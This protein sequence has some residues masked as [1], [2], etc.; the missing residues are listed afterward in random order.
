MLAAF[1]LYRLGG[2]SSSFCFS[3]AEDFARRF[4]MRIADR[5]FFDRMLRIVFVNDGAVL[6]LEPFRRREDDLLILRIEFDHAEIQR[7]VYLE[8]IAD[9]ADIAEC[10]LR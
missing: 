10:Q 1:L 3:F 5:F 9:A 7:L 6:S 4:F 2:G 8:C